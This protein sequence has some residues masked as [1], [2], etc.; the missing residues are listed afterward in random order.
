[1]PVLMLEMDD[2]RS[3]FPYLSQCTYLNTATAGLAAPGQGAAAAEFYDIDKA[4]GIQ[5]MERWRARADAA[6]E[7]LAS[8]LAVQAHSVHFV[9][10]TTEALNLIAL[11]LPLSTDDRVVVA[12]DEF[13]S[14]VLPWQTLRARG[15]EVVRVPIP[16]EAERSEALA[17]AVAGARVLAVS[18][19]HWRT[20]TRVDLGRLSAA[21]A[22]HGC[23][24]IVDGAHAVG[25]VSIDARQVDAYCAPVFKWLLSGFGLGFVTLSDSL[26]AQLE[27]ALR[28]YSNE[29]PSR[30]LSYSHVNYPGIYALHAALVHLRTLGWQHIHARVASL[31]AHTAFMLRQAGL[32]V[33]TPEGSHGGIVSFC[34]PQSGVLVQALA[35]Q[36]IFVEDGGALVRVSPHFYNMKEEVDHLVSALKHVA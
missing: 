33:L 10:S 11:S 30:S 9:G 3:S 31:A 36:S 27:P 23:R 24:L 5:G 21:C 2:V 35:R 29:P 32:D 19:V 14:V 34:H 8:L 26:A 4:E 7:E 25:A 22:K 12:E 13:A 16:R 17:V 15:V 28:G 20:G 1:M 18:H 6:R